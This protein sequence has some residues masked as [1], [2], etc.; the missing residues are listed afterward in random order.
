[1]SRIFLLI[2]PIIIGFFSVE[3]IFAEGC[4][5]KAELPDSATLRS[6]AIRCI[7]ARSGKS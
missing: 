3:Y 5:I 7:D 1:M 6:Q 2:I 4:D